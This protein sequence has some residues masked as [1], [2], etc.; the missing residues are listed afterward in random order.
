MG[1]DLPVRDVSGCDPIV[2]GETHTPVFN[3]DD[4]QK[5]QKDIDLSVWNE[6][7]KQG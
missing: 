2:C 5:V 4:L 7:S 3:L 6:K 1:Y